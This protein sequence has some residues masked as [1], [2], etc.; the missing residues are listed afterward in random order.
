MKKVFFVAI[1]LFCMTNYAI[2]AKSPSTIF[3][4]GDETMA[5]YPKLADKSPCGWGQCLPTYIRSEVIVE[6]HA[7]IGVNSTSY[8]NDGY[9]DVVLERA[10]RGDFLFIQLGLNDIEPSCED[11]PA[12]IDVLEHN[13]LQ[14]VAEAEKKNIQVILF[15]PN[16]PC[17]FKDSLFF[18]RLGGYAETIRNVAKYFQIPL[19]DLEEA[20]ALFWKNEGEEFAYQW[21][22]DGSDRLLTPDGALKISQIVYE[23]LK[24]LNIKN[25]SQK[26]KEGNEPI[27]TQPWKQE[28]N[29]EK[30]VSL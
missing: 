8:R 2:G 5:D 3:L 1:C 26:L 10:N 16:S 22:I 7:I 19:V 14:M 11:R 13:L 4:I 9:W 6:N 21:L 17:F 25:L 20:T 28:V 12:G 30:E 18:H 29:V 15:T 23:Q 24:S 27:Y